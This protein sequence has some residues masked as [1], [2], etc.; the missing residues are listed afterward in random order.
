MFAHSLI[1]ICALY[2][3]FVLMAE[4]EFGF[5]PPPTQFD[6]LYG[7]TDLA[8]ENIFGHKSYAGIKGVRGKFG[9]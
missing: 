8:E 2:L 3:G 4:Q 7:L 1:H 9:L 5:L 6:I